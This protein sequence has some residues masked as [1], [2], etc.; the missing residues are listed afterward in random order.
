MLRALLLKLFKVS[1]GTPI[2][3]CFKYRFRFIKRR[4]ESS[5][6]TGLPTKTL[7]NKQANKKQ[8]YIIVKQLYFF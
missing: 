6:Q 2:E 7:F 4:I 5:S 8:I 3:Y 1:Y